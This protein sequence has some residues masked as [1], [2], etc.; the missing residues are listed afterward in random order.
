M[1]VAAQ[2]VKRAL[3]GMPVAERNLLVTEATESAFQHLAE[4]DRNS[5]ELDIHT[6][7]HYS[8]SERRPGPWMGRTGAME[9]LAAIGRW[10]ME[11]GR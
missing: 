10:M 1:A 7:M 5:L 11:E 9:L 6:L 3:A 4:M 8:G 2:A